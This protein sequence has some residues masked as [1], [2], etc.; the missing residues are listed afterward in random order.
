[1]KKLVIL[2]F[3]FLLIAGSACALCTRTS[4]ASYTNSNYRPCSMACGFLGIFHTQDQW[5]TTYVYNC[6]EGGV[7]IVTFLNCHNG[8]CC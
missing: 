4:I 1:M 5:D 7:N 2:T 3:A 6:A 8:D